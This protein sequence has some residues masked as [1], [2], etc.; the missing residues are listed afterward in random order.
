MGAHPSVG[1]PILLP[2]SPHLTHHRMPHVLR[3][4][5]PRLVQHMRAHALYT[6][7]VESTYLTLTHD[8]YTKESS[9]LAAAGTLSAK[10]FL[11][12]AQG[13]STE[14]RERAQEVLLNESVAPVQDLTDRALMAGRLD[15]L[16]KD[17]KLEFEYAEEQRAAADHGSDRAGDT[18]GRAERRA[19]QEDVQ[20]V[21]EG[22]RAQGAQRRIQVL[23][24]GT[25]DRACIH[26][27]PC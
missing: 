25:T 9:T 13:R 27:G 2:L 24:T 18:H 6:D 22:R 8:F 23:R 1:P 4:H 20:A 21:C 3:A 10:D 12:H 17:G 14:E 15:W 11:V 7:V 26:D 19:D 16:A 5:L